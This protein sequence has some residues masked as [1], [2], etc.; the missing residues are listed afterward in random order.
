MC[1]IYC[2]FVPT[3]STVTIFVIVSFTVSHSA[4]RV[5]FGSYLMLAVKF[6]NIGINYY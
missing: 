3:R 2:T 5:T 6:Y 4:A 1:I